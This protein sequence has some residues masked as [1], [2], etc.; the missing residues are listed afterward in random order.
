MLD[1]KVIELL[2]EEY[3]AYVKEVPTRLGKDGIVERTG[4]KA[5]IRKKGGK[6]L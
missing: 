4:V 2:G 1:W 3:I 5:F 6:G